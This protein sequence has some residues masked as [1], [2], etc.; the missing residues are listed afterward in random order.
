MMLYYH[1]VPRGGKLRLILL[2]FFAV[3]FCGM[4]VICG[5]CAGK[6]ILRTGWYSGRVEGVEG[7]CR[8]DVSRRHADGDGSSLMCL[9]Y[10]VNVCYEEDA[11]FDQGVQGW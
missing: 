3:F 8:L 1:I 5:D 6:K 2:W 4:V 11:Q 9:R 10:C 7:A